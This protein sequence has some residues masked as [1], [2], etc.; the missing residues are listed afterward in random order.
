MP[1]SKWKSK[2]TKVRL[3]V[4]TKSDVLFNAEQLWEL[5]R[6]K[7]EIAKQFEDET[8]A[9]QEQK[10]KLWADLARQRMEHDRLRQQI[11]EEMWEQAFLVAREKRNLELQ[12]QEWKDREL[13][14]EQMAMAVA[15]GDD[16]K[17]KELQYKQEKKWRE[18]KW[19]FAFH[20][21]WKGDDWNKGK[22]LG[23]GWSSLKNMRESN[24][25]E[26][27]RWIKAVD[28]EEDE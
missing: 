10:E 6:Q 20:D 13:L 4:S 15:K 21:A 7:E 27:L 14:V 26:N 18:S 5:D 23:K 9:M 16:E 19:W 1:V 17:V 3:W 12:Q 2:W 25:N 24:L 11:E 22:E 28:E 8:R